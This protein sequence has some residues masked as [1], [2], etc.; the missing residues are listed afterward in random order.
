MLPP[1]CGLTP[2]GRRHEL[3]SELLYL[4]RSRVNKAEMGSVVDHC[5]NWDPALAVEQWAYSA[6]RAMLRPSAAADR[7]VGVACLLRKDGPSNL[8]RRQVVGWVEEYLAGTNVSAVVDGFQG[9]GGPGAVW[10]QPVYDDYF[11]VLA[12]TRILIT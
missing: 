1:R 12:R 2:R 3:R 11:G 10:N 4:K 5:G 7:D 6:S 8:I 9:H